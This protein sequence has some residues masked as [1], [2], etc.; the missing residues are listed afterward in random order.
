[1]QGGI[2]EIESGAEQLAVEAGEYWRQSSGRPWVQD[3]SH[4]RGRGR[5]S[6][7]QAWAALGERHLEMFRQLCALAGRTDKISRMLE[8]GPGGGANATAFAP[9]VSRFYGV[10]IS[11]A[12]LEECGR[13]LKA[14]GFDGW[15]PIEIDAAQPE[16]CLGS[17][18]EPVDFVLSTAVFQHFPGQ[19]YG[20]R[21]LKIIHEILADDG[22]ALIQIRYD[23]GS[24]VLKCKTHDYAKYVV[25]FTSYRIEEFWQLAAGIG[26][27]PAALILK[28][29][30]CYAFYLLK[31]GV[32]R[33]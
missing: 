7:E 14:I 10:D 4:W 6:D 31:K 3:M 16:Q 21:V 25:T 24:E 1:M 23:D 17:L 18:D 19:A 9:D 5:W 27:K 15:H 22:V 28:P 32:G 8:W 26:L 2:S 12:N 13:Q 29:E 33:E 11:P 30:D 20:Q